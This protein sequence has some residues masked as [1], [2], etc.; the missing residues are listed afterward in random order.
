MTGIR[1][2]IE[3]EQTISEIQKMLS[4]HGV[5]AMMTE[6]DG[7][8]IASVSFRMNV[9]D[10]P[11]GFRL[12]CNWRAVVEIFKKQGVRLKYGGTI[13][14]QATRTARRIVK[15]WIEAQLALFEV[16]MVTGAAGLPSLRDHEGQ[17]HAVGA[18]CVR[19]GVPTGRR[20]I[21]Y[22]PTG[23]RQSGEPGLRHLTKSRLPGV[24]W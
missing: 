8:Q 7:P 16:N 6:Y 23:A 1:S 10:K 20:Q 17:P 3:P 19:S 5:T 4:R 2:K 14:A 12:P 11:M 24:Q 21:M 18:R 13:E 22:E 15:D 9:G